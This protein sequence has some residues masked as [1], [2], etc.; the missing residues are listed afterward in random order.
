M[1]FDP[2]T[3][4]IVGQKTSA[5]K[6]SKGKFDPS[7]AKLVTAQ[8]IPEDQP[9]N[10]QFLPGAIN[11]LAGTGIEAVRGLHQG[12][13]NVAGN[14]NMAAEAIGQATGTTPGGAFGQVEQVLGQSAE[15][16]PETNIPPVVKAGANLVGAAGPAVAEYMLL[17][18][19]MGPAAGRAFTPIF[20]GVKVGGIPATQIMTESSILAAQSAINEYRASGGD[21][22]A[23][24]KA[25]AQGAAIGG[26]LGVTPLA[27]ELGKKFGKGAAKI[28]IRAVTEN[29]WLANDFVEHPSKYVLSMLKKVENL[30]DVT[31]RNKATMAGLKAK[32][33]Y[34]T[35]AKAFQHAQER[36][37]LQSEMERAFYKTKETNRALAASLEDR[38]KATLAEVTENATKSIQASEKSL[39][40]T[41]YKDFQNASELIALEERAAGEAVDTAVQG[42]ILKDPFA[43]VNATNFFG[44]FNEVLNQNR[45]SIV[46]GKVTPRVGSVSKK[47][48]TKVLQEILEESKGKLTPDGLPLGFVQ[49]LKVGMSKLGYESKEPIF[50]QLSGAINPLKFGETSSVGTIGTKAV[51]KSMLGVDSLI[52]GKNIQ[53][54]LKILKEANIRYTTLVPQKKEAL[55]QFTRPGADGQPIA[56]F[57]RAINAVRGNDRAALEAMR[58]ADQALAPSNRLIPKV[59]RVVK[60]MEVHQAQIDKNVNLI[61]RKLAKEKASHAEAIRKKEFEIREANDKKRFDRAQYLQGEL[62]EFK[63]KKAA[64]IR[65]VEVAF[66]LEEEFV[67][68][69]SQ[70]RRFVG[71]ARAGRLQ[72]IGILGA[73]SQFRF[74]SAISA[75]VSSG[76]TL[77]PSPLLG[78]SVVKGFGAM[79]DPM[80]DMAIKAASNPTVRKTL[81]SLLATNKAKA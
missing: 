9:S 45:Y 73:L 21:A 16:L 31:S 39:Q 15:T 55:A 4:Q 74:P 11:A 34:D 42:I 62:K 75:G 59:E 56:D 69:Q 54:E 25:G 61:R 70:L 17:S 22:K 53:E 26:V 30:T 35:D 5:P 81:G 6:A 8:N 41:L 19:A 72:T 63:A 20:G 43:T 24:L 68:G 51:N 47:E 66:H 65:E 67:R 60:D 18:K 38:S 77:L 52:N 23:T 37:G 10:E 64:E 58:K 48:T 78:A 28:F 12:I 57:S 13:S 50:Q 36:E 40:D 49:D 29:E 79:A 33:T 2:S 1:A 76:L 46:G 27:L 44:K 71:D 7:T 3:A 80:T 14:L 32:E